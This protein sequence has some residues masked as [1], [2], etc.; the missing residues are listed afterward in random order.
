[1]VAVPEP[2]QLTDVVQQLKNAVLG[3]VA[4]QSLQLVQ[5]IAIRHERQAM[6]GHMKNE[7]LMARNWLRGQAGDA[8]HV[9]LS[10]AGQNLCLIL[11]TIAICFALYF[12]GLQSYFGTNGAHL[13]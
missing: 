1:M 7:G 5:D 3:A 2:P 13:V 12:R 6:I 4:I 10:G 11:R 9:A 8:M